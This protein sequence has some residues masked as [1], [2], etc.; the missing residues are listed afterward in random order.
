M[1]YHSGTR[2]AG[3]VETYYRSL[4]KPR[5][6][7]TA[8]S[9]TKVVIVQ[10]DFWAVAKLI[11]EILGQATVVIRV[12]LQ[13][14]ADPVDVLDGDAGLLQTEID[15]AARKF[16]AS[17]LGQR[18]PLFFSGRNHATVLKQNRRTIVVAMLDTRTNSNHIH[19]NLPRS[20]AFLLATDCGPRPPSAV[21]PAIV[22]QRRYPN[23]AARD[24][25][26]RP[27]LS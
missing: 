12:G 26:I 2:V 4:G 25:R 11:F 10:F 20:S 19:I 5:S 6:V 17:M 14:R 21:H 23:G 8:R 7:I 1:R 22:R 18:K 16:A 3:K 15:R 13:W 9:M 24:G 27:A